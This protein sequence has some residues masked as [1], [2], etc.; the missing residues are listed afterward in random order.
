MVRGYLFSDLTIEISMMIVHVTK[1]QAIYSAGQEEDFPFVAG[2]YLNSKKAVHVG[3]TAHFKV[4]VSK[5]WIPV[6]SQ[7]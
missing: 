5:A 4:G 1:E 3:V 2:L 7:I 6:S